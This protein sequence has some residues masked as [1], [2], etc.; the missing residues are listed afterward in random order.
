MPKRDQDV[1]DAGDS[2]VRFEEWL[3]TGEPGILDAIETYNEVDCLS[4]V[5]LH[6]WLLDRRTEAQEQFGGGDPVAASFRATRG[7]AGGR[8]GAG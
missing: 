2:I 4:T 3:D 8:G 6:R 5:E 7:L 1:T